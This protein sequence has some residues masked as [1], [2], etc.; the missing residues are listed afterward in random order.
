MG[1]GLSF[2]L[3]L[4]SMLVL[5]SCTPDEP[6]D[7]FAHNSGIK[8]RVM[9][10]NGFQ[11]P[12]YD[13]RSGISLELHVGYQDYV[14]SADNTGDWLLNGAPV[15]T[16]TVTASKEGYSEITLRGIKISTT[17]PNFPIDNGYQK[18]PTITLTKLPLTD[19]EDFTMNLDVAVQ[20]SDT[21]YTLNISATM[22]PAPPPTG[23][24][25][26]YRIFIGEDENVSPEHYIFQEYRNTTNA[27][28]DITF[29]NAW[30][31]EKEISS[32][33]AIYAVIY[34]DVS[35]NQ[36][37]VKPDSTLVFP[38]ISSMPGGLASV[39]LP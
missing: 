2:N 8:G 31:V 7:N 9:V 18:L 27:A 14:V 21:V 25:K 10:Q 26:G 33:D 34:G 19:F 37:I 29:D 22:L 17:M 6:E 3:F 15:G 11:Q 35:F 5:A 23:Q 39:V 38:N 28:I 13:E 24:A 20:D 1:K 4:L 12:L 32:G 16:Y 30:F 36:V